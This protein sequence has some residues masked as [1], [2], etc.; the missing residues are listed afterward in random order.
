MLGSLPRFS[1]PACGPH[2]LFP[3]L[4]RR[5]RDV[6][7]RTVKKSRSQGVGELKSPGTEN[8]QLTAAPALGPLAGRP[9]ATPRLLGLSTSLPRKLTTEPGRQQHRKSAKSYERSQ[10]VIENKERHI[11][12]ELKTNSIL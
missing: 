8:R 6:E 11:E 9:L 3:L 7:S 10:Y 2:P 1:V 5:T 12:N 4:A